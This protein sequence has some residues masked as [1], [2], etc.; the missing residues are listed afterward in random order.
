[1]DALQRGR[2]QFE[3]GKSRAA[4]VQCGGGLFGGRFAVDTELGAKRLLDGT[5]G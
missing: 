2:T 4:A 3:L 1:M 5:D